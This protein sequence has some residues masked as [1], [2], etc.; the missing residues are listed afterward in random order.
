MIRTPYLLF[1]GDAPDQLAAK[2]AQGN[3]DWRSE[4]VVGKFRMPG[5]KAD[6]GAKDMTLTEAYEAG[7]RTLVVGV[8]NR[9]G[10]ISEAWIDVLCEA[11]E[12]G[13]DVASGLHN[14]LRDEKRVKATSQRA[15]RTL[16]DVR[17]PTVSYPIANGEKRSGKRAV[18]PSE[19]TARS[20]RC[21]PASP[22]TPRCAREA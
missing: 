9:G 19:P 15:G 2:V 1:L 7:A 21:T 17:V 13:Y 6:V 18:S 3:A 14:L 8:A 10:V 4:N 5:C 20:G 11:L 22:W 12:I 16:H